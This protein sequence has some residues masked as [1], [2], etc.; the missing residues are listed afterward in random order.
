MSFKKDDFHESSKSI[1]NTPNLSF[2]IDRDQNQY[3]LD[4]LDA[5]DSKKSVKKPLITSDSSDS[6]SSRDDNITNDNT[7]ATGIQNTSALKQFWYYKKVICLCALI[8]LTGFLFGWD[9]GVIGGIINMNSFITKLGHE[10]IID[11]LDPSKTKIILESYKTGAIV[12]G[13]HIGCITGGFTIAKLADT[14]GRRYPILISM[15]TYIVGILIQISSIYTGWW[16][17]FVL[18]RFTTGLCIGSVAVLSPM[19]ISE[20]APTVIRG[21]CVCL[22]GLNICGA[23]FWAS[24]TVFQCKEH[25]P[26]TNIEWILPLALG[27]L[28][29]SIASV[30]ILLTPESPRYLIS[31]ND[32]INARISLQKIGDSDIEKTLNSI[33]ESLLLDSNANELPFTEIFKKRY[34]KRVIIG[35]FMMVF[36]Q[37]SGIDY[38]FYYGTALFKYAGVE[39]SYFTS[40]ILASVNFLVTIP[41]IYIIEKLGRRKALL[42]GSVLC[43]ISLFI[44]STVG[45]FMLDANASSPEVNKT[46]GMIMVIFTCLF[47]ISFSPS[48]G[49]SAGVFVSELYPLHIKS[50]AVAFG[51][52]FNWGSNFF[53]GFCTPIISEQIGYAYGYVFTGF[54][55]IGFWFVYYMVPETQ[56]IS[57]EQISALFEN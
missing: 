32:Y 25:Y 51:I 35:V 46:P 8:S 3:E 23:I 42:I 39:D 33:Q 36:Q 5:Y 52:A 27:I 38:F 34:I 1:D 45:T 24:I 4:D 37:M 55:F 17:Q 53:I 11:P 16:I 56:G 14:L 47:I 41:G 48:W 10:I 7:I 57:L 9:T 20:T 22:Y 31:Q 43:F 12:S 50:S 26:M 28:A 29:A 44:Y 30:G 13:Y 49:A 54:M 21:S 40:I 6:E 19:L 2:E 18:G 15:A